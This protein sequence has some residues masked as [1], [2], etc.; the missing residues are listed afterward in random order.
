MPDRWYKYSESGAV[1]ATHGSQ[2]GS[3]KFVRPGT[4]L[5]KPGKDDCSARHDRQPIDCLQTG[6][7]APGDFAVVHREREFRPAL[8]QRFQRAFAFDPRQ[9]MAEAKVDAGAEGD[10]PVRP[11]RKLEPLRMLIGR[12]V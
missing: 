4:R 6:P 11:A 5:D 12:A 1:M 10:V 8:E 2:G 3:S 7:F 9:L